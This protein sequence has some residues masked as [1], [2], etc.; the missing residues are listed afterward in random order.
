MKNISINFSGL[1]MLLL[2]LILPTYRGCTGCGCTAVQDS[3]GPS[4][5]SAGVDWI[6][7]Q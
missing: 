1:M 4:L 6:K 3:I 5:S 7:K 2:L